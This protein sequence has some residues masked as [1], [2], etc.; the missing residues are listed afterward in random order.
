MPNAYFVS[1]QAPPPDFTATNSD[2]DQSNSISIAQAR[3][4]DNGNRPSKITSVRMYLAGRNASRSVKISISGNVNGSTDFFTVASGS[5]AANT[6]FKTMS[7]QSRYTTTPASA[8]VIMDT[9]GSIY[10]GND[11]TGGS[12]SVAGIAGRTMWGEYSYIQV[13]ATPSTPSISADQQNGSVT[14]SW[15]GISDWGDS[16]SDLGYRVY[17]YMD[18]SLLDSQD[19]GSF[20]TSATFSLLA[21]NRNYSARISAYN[22]IRSFNNEPMSPMS[23]TSSSVFLAEQ[24]VTYT[25]SYNSDGGSNNPPSVVVNSGST[26]ILP[27]PG[28]RSGYTFNGWVSSYTG[29]VFGVGSTS[30]AI[31]ANTTF[32]AWWSQ[33]TWT[34]TFN[35][36]GGTTPSAQTVPQGSSITLPS[37]TRSG[38]TFT[39][40]WTASSGGSF[41]GNANASYTP[42]N[43]ITLFAQWQALA[44]GFTDEIVTG[45][46]PININVNTLPD[47]QVVA[48]NAVSYSLIASTGTFPTW[49]SINN[50]GYL[51]GSTNI[52]GTYT[53]K[54]RA[55]GADEQTADSNNITINVIYPGKRA[56]SGS[57]FTNFSSAK[58]YNGTTWVNITSMKRYNGTSWVDI[59]N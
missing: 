18:G 30:H 31:V 45:T 8:T 5:A 51:S 26:V 22:E 15:S 35:G 38:F 46:V 59:T 9:N 50:S 21:R 16:S 54:V 40:W 32:T 36:N 58:R 39:G 24:I 23:S 25:V 48:T 29:G 6:G 2:L 27:S 57:T 53:F 37:S 34:V 55:T 28:T 49:L 20:T 33:L 10:I 11:N 42:S 4:A 43:N 52:A 14:V 44:P 41:I 1:G 47:N 3:L 7:T 13:P 56:T 12:N 17:L 19:V